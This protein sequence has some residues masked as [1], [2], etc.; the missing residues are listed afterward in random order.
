MGKWSPW[1]SFLRLRQQLDELLYA[2]IEERREKP[3]PKRTD[4]LSLLM[5]ARDENGQGM[6][7]KELRDQSITLLFVGH[8]NTATA[9]AWS[10]YWVH[11][12]T[13]VREKLLQE[14]DSLGDAPE[15]MT[16]SR[17]PYLT[18]VCNETLRM[19]SVNMM[20]S[21]R[22]VR[23]PIELMGYQLP[24]GT[25]LFGSIYLTHHREDLY[26]E[27]KQFRPERFIEREYSPYEF[28]PF[29][30]GIRSCIGAS[31]AQFEMRLVLA[32]ALSR[33]QLALGD[34]Q[35]E[36]LQGRGIVLVPAGGVK[37]VVQDKRV[38]RDQ[39]LATTVG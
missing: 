32:T 4:V 33:Y 20:T 35:P 19:S 12:D 37:M 8:E 38:R 3:D 15:P 31:L 17:L 9:I 11:K 28:L 10:L 36:R 39:E 14:L 24:P 13:R 21:G 23:S 34:T 18:A 16:I 26:P 25:A 30:G 6:T 27:P 2:E 29:G 5:S 22:V 7:N 1:G